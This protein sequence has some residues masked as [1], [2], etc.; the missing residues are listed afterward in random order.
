MSSV[1]T[2]IRTVGI[3]ALLKRIQSG[4]D[5]GNGWLYTNTIGANNIGDPPKSP[6][7]MGELPFINLHFGDESCANA[8]TGAALQT[9]GNRQLWHNSFDLE[10]DV[11]MSAEDVA[12]AQENMLADVLAAFG[13]DYTIAGTVFSCAYKS[14]VNF[15]LETNRPNCG[16]TIVFT[17]WYRIYQTNPAISG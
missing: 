9:G 16:I 13:N 5:S 15:G 2:N 8:N 6:E 11:F 17:V 12:L 14:S 3:P 7:Q 4:V 1:K 10:M